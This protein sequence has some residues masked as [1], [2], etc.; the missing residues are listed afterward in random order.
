MVVHDDIG[1]DWISRYVFTRQCL[2][3]KLSRRCY[4]SI[5]WAL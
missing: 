1:L 5:S 4:G 3:P 2:Q